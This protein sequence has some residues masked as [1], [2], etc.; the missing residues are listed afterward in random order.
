[1]AQRRRRKEAQRL[2]RDRRRLVLSAITAGILVVVLLTAAISYKLW[3]S[4]GSGDQSKY[5]DEEMQEFWDEHLDSLIV[6]LITGAHAND[7]VNE[8]IQDRNRLINERYN[9]PEIEYVRIRNYA[10]TENIPMASGYKNGR[11][12]IEFIVPAIMDE[13]YAMQ[14]YRYPE[15]RRLFENAITIGYL[16][17]LD[18]LAFDIIHTPST[19]EE[20]IQKESMAWAKTA[21]SIELLVT[22]HAFQLHAS[23][24][25][26]YNAWV[27][28]G[29]QEDSSEWL[30]YIRDAYRDT[31][32]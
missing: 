29:R 20:R 3:F 4:A 8:I 21:Q 14:A 11:A 13:F 24:L 2:K 27:R 30:D 7:T 6:E 10:V 19:F 1:M 9:N 5:N 31:A 32:P 28:S 17:E 26:Y 18:H 25:S 15:R 23:D 12:F 16:H 22:R